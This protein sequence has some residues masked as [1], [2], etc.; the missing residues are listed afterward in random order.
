MVR[1]L[2]TSALPYANGPIHFGHVVGAYLP[3]D[4]YVRTLRMHGE[5]VL[6]VCGADEHGVAITIGAERENQPYAEYVAHWRGVIKS[7][8][9]RLGIRFDV[10]SGT[11]I[12]PSHA[13]LSQDFFRRLDIGGY[14]MQR[15]EQQLYCTTDARFLA[16]RYIAGTCPNCGY[17]EARGDECPRCAKW[18]NPLEFTDPRCKVCGSTPEKRKTRHWYLDLPKL[19]D[20]KLGEWAAAHEWKPNVATFVANQLE[21]V[22]PR[23]ITRDMHWGVPVPED[24]ARGESGKVLY[25]WF[26]APIGYVS[27]T[28]DWAEAHGAPD[29]WQKWWRSPDTRLVHFIGK[30]NIPFHCVV[31]PAM[32]WGVKQDYVLPWHVP[33]NE[34]Y[35]LEGRKFSTSQGWYVDLDE[36]FARYD[37]DTARFYLLASSPETKD[38]DFNWKDFQSANN[39]LLADTIGNLASRVLKFLEKYY[40]GQIP[41]VSAEH[42]AEFDRILLTECGA[43]ADPGA[44][45]L[46]F[47]F[48]RGT[49]DLAAN[50]R[51]ANVFVDRVAP[52]SLRKTDPERAGAALATC[53][54][55][56]ALLAQWMAPILPGKAQRLWTMLGNLGEVGE[57]RWPK[58]PVAGAWRRNLSGQRIGQVDVLFP[59]IDDAVIAAEIDALHKRAAATS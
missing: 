5:E 4:V 15:E 1:Y 38:S 35:N 23:P 13:E 10:W 11:S 47:R 37:A 7:T 20:E 9:D 21:E 31:F 2:V 22:E 54:E 14:L 41:A 34:F 36:F 16:D 27:F 52:W 49:E 28:R 25:V 57:Q 55:W 56:L 51:V 26:D 29:D 59:K 39:V 8:F 58:L 17:P 12:S 33:A 53:C 32:L 30:D 43:F 48:R 18:L 3:A 19:R 46:D 45:L 42:A 40:E 50:A 44:A 24:R 6:Y